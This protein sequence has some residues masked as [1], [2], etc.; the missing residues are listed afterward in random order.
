MDGHDVHI[1]NP[2]DSITVETSPY[3]IPCINRPIPHSNRSPSTDDAG[4]LQDGWVQDINRL[5]NFNA[6]FRSSSLA[7]LEYDRE[8]L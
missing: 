6:S 5:L 7:H 1:L 4:R 2:G 8:V 3:P